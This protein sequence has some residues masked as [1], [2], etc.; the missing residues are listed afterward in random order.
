MK[1]LFKEKEKQFYLLKHYCPFNEIWPS[2]SADVD[3]RLFLI[4]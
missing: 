2:D 1:H 4:A 3:N